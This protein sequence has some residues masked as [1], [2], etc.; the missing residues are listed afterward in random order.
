MIKNV[1]LIWA[2]VPI[3]IMNISAHK[4]NDIKLEII[5]QFAVSVNPDNSVET[6]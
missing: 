4:E 1:F 3:W 6:E 5:Q 2:S